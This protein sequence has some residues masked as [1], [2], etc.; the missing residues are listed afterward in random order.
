[1]VSPDTANSNSDL[2]AIE[3]NKCLPVL[4]PVIESSNRP[5]AVVDREPSEKYRLRRL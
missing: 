2:P 4:R 1:M 5:T 3:E